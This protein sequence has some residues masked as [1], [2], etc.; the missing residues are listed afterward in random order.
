MARIIQLNLTLLM[1]TEKAFR[2]FNLDRFGIK[3]RIQG[4][5]YSK[6][7]L[8]RNVAERVCFVNCQV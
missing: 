4:S 1:E 6:A 3:A 8:P 2:K 7:P 5:H